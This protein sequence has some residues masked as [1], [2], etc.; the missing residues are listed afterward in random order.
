MSDF[1]TFAR[2]HGLIINDTHPSSRIRRCGTE[3]K[4]KSKN[5]AYWYD[6]ERGWVQDWGALGELFW[7]DDPDRQEPTPEMRARW[8][9]ERKQRERDQEILWG[10]TATQAKRMLESCKTDEHN[11]LHRKGLGDMKGL[12]TPDGELFVPMYDFK[13]EALVGYQ[14]IFWDEPNRQWLKKMKYGT[15]LKGAGLRLGP[16]VSD[17]V[18]LCEGYATGLTINKAMAQMRLP[19]TVLICFNA[20]N[21]ITVA[22][23][24]KGVRRCYVFADNDKSQTGEKAAQAT[25]FKYCMSPVEGEDA[26]DLY[27]RAGLMAVC[28]LIMEARKL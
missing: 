13:T 1:F 6:G 3:A 27:V 18:V 15:R 9:A 5:G 26:N 14:T 25:G 11:Y 21:M 2:A 22:Q 20:S 12:V 10:K 19:A 8:E 23:M 24:I 16:K 4:P 17:E 28:K 7:W